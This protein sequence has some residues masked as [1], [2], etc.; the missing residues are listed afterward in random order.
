[1]ARP[2]KETTVKEIKEKIGNAKVTV[3]ADFTGLDV[4]QIG[5]LRKSLRKEDIE[6]K[7]FKNTLIRIATRSKKLKGLDELLS[8][9]TAL[10][11]GYDD[12]ITA[13]KVLSKFFKKH[14]GPKIKGGILEGEVVDSSQVKSLANLPSFEELLAKLMGS[15]QAPLSGF[16]NVLSGS[17]RG[18]VTVLNGIT[19][20]K[21]SE[22]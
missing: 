14:G 20:Q 8:G 22:N 9:P 21:A 19:K 4:H 1:M 5:E 16:A 13:P 6:Y 12:E 11:F 17:T 7:V 18:L 10:A 3:L 2:E 15:M